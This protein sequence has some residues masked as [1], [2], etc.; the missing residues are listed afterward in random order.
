MLCNLYQCCKFQDRPNLYAT[1][2]SH[3]DTRTILSGEGVKAMK[4]EINVRFAAEHFGILRFI[5]KG[6]FFLL[7]TVCEDVCGGAVCTQRLAC[8]GGCEITSVH[9]QMCQT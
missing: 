2:D 6:F 9:L 4:S 8:V 7:Q 1:C 5:V 3:R